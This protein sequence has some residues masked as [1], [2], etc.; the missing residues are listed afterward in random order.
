MISNTEILSALPALWRYA[1][2]LRGNDDPED[3][4]QITCEKALRQRD[5][6]TDGDSEVWLT[7]I[8]RN[9]NTD[10]RRREAVRG[11]QVQHDAISVPPRQEAIVLAIEVMN[12]VERLPPEFRRLLALHAAGHSKQEAADIEG[13]PL[14]TQSSRMSRARARLVEM[15]K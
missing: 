15:L 12:T 8:M 1:R 13:I 5:Q 6:F 3:L 2:F 14:G 11:N 9:A 7:A 10:L 4:L